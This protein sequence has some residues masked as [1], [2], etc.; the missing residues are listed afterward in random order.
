VKVFFLKFAG[1][2]SKILAL[3]LGHVSPLKLLFLKKSCSIFLSIFYF[4]INTLT[5]IIFNIYAAIVG[6]GLRNF[7]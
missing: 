7:S 6:N 5:K 1:V 2:Y 3:G 4:L